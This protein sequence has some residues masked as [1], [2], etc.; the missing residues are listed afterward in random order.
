LRPRTR[1]RAAFFALAG[2]A[3]VAGVGWALLGNRVLVVRSVSVTG[4]HLLTPGQVIAAADVSL[5]TPLLSV[6]AGTVTRRVEAIPNVA[7]ASVTED[8]PDHLVI[9]VTERVPVLAVRMA[10]GG[11]DLVDPSGVIVRMA[12]ARPAGLPLL[13]T[14][15]AGSAL[16]GNPQVTTTAAVL[17][18]LKPWLAGQV[19][20]L[21]AATAAGPAQVTLSLRDGKTV[22]WGSPGNAAQK[23]RE[24]SVLLPGNVHD[25]D[26]SSP[27][28]VVTK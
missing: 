14:S 16:R 25:V 11:Y 2:V 27:G 28:T 10:G 13:A 22:Q 23:N 12:K 17:A 21:R 4:T 8:W 26:V 20:G 6:D 5:G 7:S 1:W 19:T 3:I 9:A 18:E 15:L 24:L